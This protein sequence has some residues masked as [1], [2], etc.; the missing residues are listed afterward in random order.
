MFNVNLDLAEI[1]SFC[2]S[3]IGLG[4][5]KITISIAIDA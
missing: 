1:V 3:N 2:H 5:K 4:D